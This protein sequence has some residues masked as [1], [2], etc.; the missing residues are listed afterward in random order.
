[1]DKA[2]R[3]FVAIVE[4][5]SLSAAAAQLF[6]SQPTLTSN[7]K[8]LE[9]QIGVPLLVRSHRGVR[10]TQY[11]EKLYENTRL[12]LRVYDGTVEAIQAQHAKAARSLDIACG[13]TWWTLAVRGLVKDHAEQHPS[14]P[15]RVEVAHQLRCLELLVTEQVALFVSNHIGGLSRSLGVHFI[16]LTT[17]EQGYFVRPSHPLLTQPRTLSEVFSYPAVTTA[18][19]PEP[20][21]QKFFEDWSKTSEIN[22][23]YERTRFGFTS[24]SMAACLDHV[25]DTD[26]VFGHTSLLEGLFFERGLKRVELLEAPESYPAGIH[27]LRENM[28]EPDVKALVSKL[29][30]AIS[31]H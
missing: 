21:Y 17:V 20:R 22:L 31:R 1:M 23:A 19:P 28:G 16:P 18:P 12:M 26:A 4:A 10:L 15:I 11:G 5:G 2:L 25:E 3:Q 13:Y 8:R 27:V 6:M 29:S 24:N 9:D 7:M 14:A 30:K